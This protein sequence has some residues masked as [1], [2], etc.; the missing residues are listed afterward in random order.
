[1]QNL[2]SLPKSSTDIVGH[3]VSSVCDN[4]D[5][6]LKIDKINVVNCPISDQKTKI[7]KKHVA[8]TTNNL[9]HHY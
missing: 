1:M 2:F 9:S 6:E 8:Y 3:N 5:V 4:K 7:I